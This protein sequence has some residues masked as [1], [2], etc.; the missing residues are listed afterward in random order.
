ML[1]GEESVLTSDE[2]P[3]E[4]VQKVEPFAFWIV[5]HVYYIFGAREVGFGSEYA[6]ITELT[7]SADLWDHK[8]VPGIND[9]EVHVSIVDLSGID[10]KQ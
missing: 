6:A 3:E 5:G 1:S 10:S 4:G 7:D 2:S 9:D 8:Q